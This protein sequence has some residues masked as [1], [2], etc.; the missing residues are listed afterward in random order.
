M[1]FRD[2]VAARGD[3]LRDLA[4]KPDE[5]GE[6]GDY[7][8]QNRGCD[9]GKRN[10]IAGAGV[11]GMIPVNIRIAR[12]RA[13]AKMASPVF[14]NTLAYWVPAPA[15]PIVGATVFKVRIAESGRSMFAL[16]AFVRTA[17]RAPRC[18]ALLMEDGVFVRRLAS[19]CEQMNSGSRVKCNVNRV[20][21]MSHSENTLICRERIIQSID[22]NGEW[23]GDDT[24]AR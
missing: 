5:R 24:T 12:V 22:R 23:G 17:Q 15:A 11:F 10:R 16:Y 14:P 9:P 6:T 13:P 21:N 3:Q 4:G 1:N 7:D 8:G 18:S 19:S 20:F 2:D